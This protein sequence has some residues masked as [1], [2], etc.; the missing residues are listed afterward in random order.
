MDISSKE[1]YSDRSSS[2]NR[3]EQDSIPIVKNKPKGF[4]MNLDL[5][6]ISLEKQVNKAKKMQLINSND[7]SERSDKSTPKSSNRVPIL[8][9]NN[10][11][12]AEEHS[13][14]ILQK[15]DPTLD[16]QL[17]DEY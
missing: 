3:Y 4:N 15:Y 12:S 9:S 5:N 10:L 6:Q 16:D 7:L 2:S 1:N 13:K 11:I 17:A 8:R 14:Q